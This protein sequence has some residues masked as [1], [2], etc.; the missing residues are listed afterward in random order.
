M[1][2]VGVSAVPKFQE[3]DRSAAAVQS[4]NAKGKAP[5][6]SS[7]APSAVSRLRASPISEG[8]EGGD[9]WSEDE[10]FDVDEEN[11][12]DGAAALVRYSRSSDTSFKN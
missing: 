1:Q 6:E 11:E 10:D 4:A 12:D 8:E 9:G 2:A 3:K 5:S 7:A